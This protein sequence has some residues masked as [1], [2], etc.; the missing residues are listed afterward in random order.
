MY[1]AHLALVSHLIKDPV[2]HAALSAVDDLHAL[3]L[4]NT[5]PLITLLTHILR[6]RI[7]VSAGMWDQVGSAL[8][9]AEEVLGLDYPLPLQTTTSDANATLARTSSGSAMP[10]ALPEFTDHFR[11]AMLAHTL[12]MGVLFHT[13]SGNSAESMPR[14]AHLH[15]LLDSGKVNKD[16]SGIVEVRVFGVAFSGV[17]DTDDSGRSLSRRAHHYTSKRP[18]RAFCTSSRSW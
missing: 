14:L 2:P 18:H 7:L 5:H 17:V 1:T 16:A 15:L 8:Q 9:K 12:I 4:A 6:L 10:A 11:V 13:Y 3:S